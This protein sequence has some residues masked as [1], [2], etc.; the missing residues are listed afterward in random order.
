MARNR[1]V[2]AEFKAAD[3]AKIR[4]CPYIHMYVQSVHADPPIFGNGYVLMKDEFRLSVISFRP[5]PGGKL[6][7]NFRVGAIVRMHQ[8]MCA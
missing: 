3:L 4:A 5:F 7:T 6:L 8:M 1:V 2:L